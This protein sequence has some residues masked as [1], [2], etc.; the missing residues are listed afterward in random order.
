MFT[1][2][3]FGPTDRLIAAITGEMVFGGVDTNKYA[4]LLHKVPTDPSDP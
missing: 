1:Q 4:G 3:V 2:Y